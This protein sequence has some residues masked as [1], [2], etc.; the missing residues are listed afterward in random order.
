MG[1]NRKS[2]PGAKPKGIRKQGYADRAKD[3]VRLQY[4]L[5]FAESK[6]HSPGTNGRAIRQMMAAAYL[7]SREFPSRLRFSYYVDRNGCLRC[8]SERRV[9][10]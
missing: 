8:V 2:L 9:V 3:Q 1:R 5:Q 4:S 10:G 6:R 7:M